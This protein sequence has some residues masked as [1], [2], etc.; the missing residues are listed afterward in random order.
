MW[1]ICWNSLPTLT[2]MFQHFLLR[3]MN[4]VTRKPHFG[5]PV[6]HFISFETSGRSRPFPIHITMSACQ[7]GANDRGALWDG[8]RV[9][10]PCD[11]PEWAAGGWLGGEDGSTHKGPLKDCRLGT[12]LALLLLPFHGMAGGGCRLVLTE[13]RDYLER[14]GEKRF[15]ITMLRFL[16]SVDGHYV[17]FCTYTIVLCGLPLHLVHTLQNRLLCCHHQKTS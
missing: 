16:D 7:W 11:T 9:E 17:Q 3:N 5:H 2:H 15:I 4:T 6:R 10:M 14:I 13:W 1:H 8:R 12:R